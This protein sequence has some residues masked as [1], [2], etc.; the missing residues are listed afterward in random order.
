[1]RS[2]FSGAPHAGP[3]REPR[4]PTQGLSVRGSGSAL[5]ARAVGPLL[6][7]QPL[8]ARAERTLRGAAITSSG[9]KCGGQA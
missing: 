3:K 4:A 6:F 8:A 7:E 2:G 5:V 1:V 9:A